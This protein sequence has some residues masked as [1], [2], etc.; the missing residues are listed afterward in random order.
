M[1]AQ[2]LALRIP[3]RVAKL[4]LVSTSGRAD[5]HLSEVLLSWAA[6]AEAGVPAA[7]RH[8]SS[9]L[10]CLGRESL[11]T[12]VARSYLEARARSARVDA[13]EPLIRFDVMPTQ[14]L[15][16]RPIVVRITCQRR[17]RV[18]PAIVPSS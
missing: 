12:D 3:E 14:P 16:D 6:F 8:R 5:A 7:L 11:E 9:L 1:I 17:R 2:E 10:W 15:L 13:D 18:R 4:V